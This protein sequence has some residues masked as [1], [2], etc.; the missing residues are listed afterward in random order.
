MALVLAIQALLLGDGG[1]LSLGANVVNMALFPAGLVALARRT[2]WLSEDNLQAAPRELAVVAA[3][4]AAAVML[5]AGL[6]VAEVALFRSGT[7]LAGWSAFAQQMLSVH[8]VIALAEGA[9]TAALAA[10]LVWFSASS[11]A[12]TTQYRPAL[13]AAALAAVLALAIPLSSDLPDGYESAAAA[14]G[15][16]GWLE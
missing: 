2:K 16:A 9:A 1:T 5:A 3:L 15:L 14:S 12:Q 6:I 7:Q 4:S 8:L 10:A 13:I 11:T